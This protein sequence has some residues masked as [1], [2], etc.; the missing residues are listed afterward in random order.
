MDVLLTGAYGIVGTALLD[1]LPSDRYRITCLDQMDPPAEYVKFPHLVAD[2]ADYESIRSAFDGV[3]AVIHLAGCPG[4]H[5]SWDKVLRSNIVGTH[6]VIEAARDAEVDDVV[7]ASSTHVV[8]LYESDS[9]PE[10]YSPDHELTIRPSDPVRPN[11]YYAVSK[12]FGE[13]LGQFYAEAQDAPDQFYVLRFGG[14][15]AP[16]YDHPYGDAEQGVDTG[17]W[18]RNGDEYERMAA[19]L[20]ALWLSRRDVAHLV[21]CCLRDRTV[22]FDIFFGVSNND[23]R[24]HDLEH[25]KNVLGFDPRDSADEWNGPPNLDVN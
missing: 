5:C 10:V 19:R 17:E 14:V 8:G 22:E 18:D 6:A 21:D 20:R 7:F 23:A 11:S 16:A 3:D 25:A 15:R 1:N 9:I 12:L 24:W 4:P 2:I 13:Q